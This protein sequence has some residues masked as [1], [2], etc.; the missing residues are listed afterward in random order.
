VIVASAAGVSSAPAAPCNARAP[1]STLPVGAS[2]HPSEVAP[3][4]VTPIAKMRRAPKMSPSDPPTR[5]SDPSV[6][7]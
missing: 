3:K 1:I 5:I 2:A 6:S 7:R 4:A